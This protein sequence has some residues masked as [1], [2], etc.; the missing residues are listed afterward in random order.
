MFLGK[1]NILVEAPNLDK[2]RKRLGKLTSLKVMGVDE[3][4][5]Y[6]L[7]EGE[8]KEMRL[9]GDWGMSY[10]RSRC[11]NALHIHVNF[12]HRFEDFELVA[13]LVFHVE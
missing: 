4:A 13:Y 1:S 6:G 2:V 11:L 9:M 3:E 7:G 12:L 5:V 10:R 8:E